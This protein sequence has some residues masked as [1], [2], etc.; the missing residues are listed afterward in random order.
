MSDEEDDIV[1]RECAVC[2]KKVTF[3]HRV[4]HSN[5]KTL[6]RWEPN[7]HPVRAVVKGKVVRIRVCTRCLRSG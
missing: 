4:S 6:R 7:L 5:R 2:A 3:G 1:A